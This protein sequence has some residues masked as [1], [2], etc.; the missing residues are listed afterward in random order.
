[1]RKTLL[2]VIALFSTGVIAEDMQ[3]SLNKLC[4][5]IQH[6][7]ITQAGSSANKEMQALLQPMLDAMCQQMEQGY[8]EALTEQPQLESEALACVQSLAALSC[9][10]LL[11]SKDKESVTKACETYKKKAEALNN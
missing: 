4:K 2:L 5:T 11:S 6:C 7:A 3:G 8:T 1:M 9:D 10:E